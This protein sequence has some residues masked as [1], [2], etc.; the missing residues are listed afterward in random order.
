MS[1]KYGEDEHPVLYVSKKLL[2]RECNYAIVEKECL[3]IIWSIQLLKYYL[4]GQ[5]FSVQT[6]HRALQWL[7]KMRNKNDRLTQWNLFLQEYRFKVDFRPGNQNANA[8]YL[9]RIVQNIQSN[10]A[11]EE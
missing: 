3:A 7:D 6:D 2:P 4:Y 1:Q 5:E 8:D 9:S 11:L 10:F